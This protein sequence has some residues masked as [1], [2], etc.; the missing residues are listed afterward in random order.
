MRRIHCAALTLLSALAT[1]GWGAAAQTLPVP[2]QSP[3]FGPLTIEQ[4]AAARK[5]VEAIYWRHRIWPQENK[6]PKPPLS[7]VLPDAEIRV[8]VLDALR[9]SQALES[10]WDRT[11]TRDELQSELDRMARD[12]RD[13]RMLRE[14]F[15]ALGD[16]PLLI[17]ETLVRPVLADRLIRARY[18]ADSQSH[19]PFDEWWRTA[20]A[21]TRPRPLAAQ[22]S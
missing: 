21:S 6:S 13:P 2:R 9:K 5:A 17:V 12:S 8:R 3:V 4:R 20:S 16:D 11:I 19:L 1:T 18:D 15:E 7:A 10:L 14:L 22:D